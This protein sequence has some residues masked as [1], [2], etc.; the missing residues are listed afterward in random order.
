MIDFDNAAFV[1][2]RPA[3]GK[4][5]AA[6]LAKLLLPGEE[7]IAAFQGMRDGVVF[8]GKRV[9]AINVQGM[10]GRKRDFTSLPY[11]KVQAFSVET[12]GAMHLDS[13]LDLWFSGLGKVRFCFALDV[14]VHQLAALIGGFVL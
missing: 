9:I 14:N 8:T 7:V 2:L 11:S 6:D 4:A 3:D 10:T 13:E 1:K 12:A 5:Y